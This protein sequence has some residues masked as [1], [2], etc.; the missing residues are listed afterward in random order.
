MSRIYFII[1]G[2]FVLAG[3]IASVFAP[4][5]N[6]GALEAFYAHLI[7]IAPP[8]FVGTVISALAVIIGKLDELL[9]KKDHVAFSAASAEQE[10]G[11]DFGSLF[12]EKLRADHAEPSPFEPEARLLFEETAVETTAVPEPVPQPAA[13]MRRAPTVDEFIVRGENSQPASPRLAREG[14]FA[15]RNYRMYE[16][17]SLE[18]DTDQS[19][20]RFDSL[21]EFRSFVSSAAAS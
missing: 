7:L 6:M 16:D 15:G 13:S 8:L 14:V 21:D 2:A 10:R 4:T 19:T 17:G 11:E 1:A 9:G 12:A 20:I 5:E 3:L 18:I